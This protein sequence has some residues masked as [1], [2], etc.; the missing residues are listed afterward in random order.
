MPI[1]GAPRQYHPKFRFIVEIDGILNGSFQSCSE[2]ASEFGEVAQW[3]G[4][5]MIPHKSAG[6]ITVDDVTL[7]R[8][9]TGNL[10]LY[11]WHK[12][13]GDAIANAGM[14]EPYYKRNVDVRQLDRAGQTIR[15]WRLFGA[16]P[17]RFVAGD[18][19]NDAD[20]NVVE[21]ITLAIDFYEL[22]GAPSIF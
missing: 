7:A 14:N 11:L 19:D 12:S 6:R 15:R 2:L 16:W 13:I 17:K 9:V 1:L 4:G 3:E 21:Q 5:T 20:E 22:V 10:E 8:G 18:W